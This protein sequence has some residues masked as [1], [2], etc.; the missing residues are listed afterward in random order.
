[1]DALIK[2]FNLQNKQGAFAAISAIDINGTPLTL[3]FKVKDDAALG[4]TVVSGEWGKIDAS[5]ASGIISVVPCSHFDAEE[6]D[7]IPS[8]VEVIEQ[9][10]LL[11]YS[12]SNPNLTTIINKTG[13]SFNWPGIILGELE[14]QVFETGTITKYNGV[15]TISN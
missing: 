8:T 2:D 13:R 15:I 3:T 14:P 10:A 6:K 11:K 9:L 12:F 1:L 5:C 7:E 4:E